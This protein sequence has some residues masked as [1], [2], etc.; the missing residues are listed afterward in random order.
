MLIQ[1][2]PLLRGWED[3]FVKKDGTIE[4]G[5]FEEIQTIEYPSWIDYAIVKM[6]K[7]DSRLSFRPT[8]APGGWERFRF[9]PEDLYDRG[10]TRA[11]PHGFWTP[12]YDTTED[13]YV[14][15]AARTPPQYTNQAITVAISAIEE[16]VYEYESLSILITDM[17]EFKMSLAEVFG[18]IR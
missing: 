7:R 2:L 18:G 4:A 11:G 9:T 5:G 1:L 15:V 13:V 17:D 12:R 10:L 6:D 16:T 14:I 3:D 8:Y